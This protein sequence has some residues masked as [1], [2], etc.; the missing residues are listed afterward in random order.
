MSKES[1][2]D[3][4]AE[5]AY[6]EASFPDLFW[7]SQLTQA[8][9]L[10]SSFPRAFAEPQSEPTLTQPRAAKERN[11]FHPWAEG[12][13]LLCT[14]VSS[15]VCG[16]KCL[17]TLQQGQASALV[18]QGQPFVTLEAATSTTGHSELLHLQSPLTPAVDQL[19]RS[20]VACWN[21]TDH[22][23]PKTERKV[24]PNQNP[25]LNVLGT[26]SELTQQAWP[27]PKCNCLTALAR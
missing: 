15:L 9:S 18:C 6:L 26:W 5:P 11:V 24:H 17:Q 16:S 7:L 23:N 12:S 21:R 1:F 3:F 25:N 13:S 14:C 27:T 19:R 8:S 10:K 2:T 4:L 22:Q 20:T